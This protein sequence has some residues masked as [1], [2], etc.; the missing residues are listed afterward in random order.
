MSNFFLDIAAAISRAD[1]SLRN[2]VVLNAASTASWTVGLMQ[3]DN[4]WQKA[5]DNDSYEGMMATMEP[6]GAALATY[7]QAQYQIDTQGKDAQSNTWEN[8]IQMEQ[9]QTNSDGDARK[10]NFG[11]ADGLA[12]T[13]SHII[14]LLEN[15]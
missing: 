14:G 9:T 10:G 3:V 1:D 11:L 7:W 8:I 15:F 5:L 13:E 12:A 2:S 6:G 4:D